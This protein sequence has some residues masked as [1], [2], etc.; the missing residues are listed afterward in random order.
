MLIPQA[1]SIDTLRGM[2]D[3]TLFLPTNT[4]TYY[5]VT[6][7]VVYTREVT[8]TDGTVN[9]GPF[10]GSANGEFYMQDSSVG[11][12]VF[13]AGGTHTQPRQGDIVM[14]TAPLSQFADRLN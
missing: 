8:N 6:N 3:S 2:V 9:G 5:T 14:V 7:A 10:T 12:C 11:I 1:V 4:T 13:V